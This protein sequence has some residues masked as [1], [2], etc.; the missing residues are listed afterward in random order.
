[1]RIS[2]HARLVQSIFL[3]SS[4]CFWLA[5]TASAQDAT[6]VWNALA[7]ASFDP[8]KSATAENVVIQHD[9]IRITLL[10]GTIQF[11]RVVNG[12]VFG[13]AFRGRGKVEIDPPNS[14]EAHQLYL[15]VGNPKLNLEFTDAVLSF[16]DDTLAQVTRQVRWLP[17]P[18]VDLASLYNGRQQEREDVG[19]ELLPRLF[20]SVLS[21]D[22][23]RTALFAADVKTAEKGWVHLRFDALQPEE[24][25][26]GRFANWGGGIGFDTWMKFPAGGV[27]AADAFR[28]PMAREDFLIPDYRIDATVTGG[29]EL[30]AATRL[31]L[32]YRHAG[33]RVF[34][35]FLTSNL[36]VESVKDSKGAALPFFQ[37]RE[38]K[39]RNQSYGD[40]VAV[41][42]PQPTQAGAADTLE[43]RYAG[44]RVI[45]KVG[46]GNFFC[47]SYG[48]YPTLANS[49]A[50][51]SNF[52]MTFRS[53]KKYTLVVTG[54]KVSE[55]PD[56]DNLLSTWKSE[57]PLAVVG[58][59]FGD[60]KL[61]VEKVGAIDVEVYANR[62]PDENM[63][64][65]KTIVDQPMTGMDQTGFGMP[66]MGTLSPAAMVKTMGTELA[67]TVRVFEKYFGPFPFK[68]LAVTNI[69]YAYGQ[70]WPTLLYLS[71]LSF[72]DS[73]QRN[74]LGIK[75]QLEL[76]DF[77]RAHESSHQWW[78][79][80]VGWKSYHDQW[81]SEGFA[82]FSGNLYIQ[83]RQDVGEY[84]NRIRQ[85][86]L[87]MTS[88]DLRSRQYQSLG[89]VWMGTR[90]SSSDAPRGYSAVI[91]YKGGLILHMLR[92]MMFDTRAKEPDQRFI[93]MMQDFTKT[94]FN[95]PASTE[96][97]KAV[98][99]K[100]ITPNLDLDGNRR[101]DW[102]FRQYVYG[103]GIP[104][105]NMYYQVS[106]NGDGKWK[107]SGRIGQ[108][109]VPEGWKDALALYQRVGGK[110]TR[111]GWITV[112]QKDTP[113]DFVLPA[114]P[115]KLLLNHSEDT[116]ADIKQ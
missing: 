31:A 20:K 49:F 43:F 26:V 65:I 94:Y 15:F 89:P 115:E 6:Q 96:D 28:D 25:L 68:R 108:S 18:P 23:K 107:I 64:L 1:M 17:S 48:W 105:Y 86:K 37:P 5:A 97:F 91:Y 13:A 73:T 10:S 92:M 3:V 57:I 33:E 109:G 44:K 40:Y 36:R 87:Y 77:F 84:V 99:E 9:R 74:A 62:D 100:H 32:S 45:R 71:A 90:L 4:F 38:Q 103:T 66:A 11:S 2:R 70:G 52:D 67:N 21:G 35:F 22:P 72:L 60:Y 95:K 102:F 93:A 114:K 98:A 50:T 34:L 79:H 47:Q 27:S 112:T 7:Q 61:Q 29:A 30:S 59:A 12:V 104:T 81:L 85:D 55:T 54:Q 82:Q 88:G 111:L 80:A 116:L 58:F 16:A 113:F 63:N 78:G 76:S 83:Y 101:L 56:G 19:V 41:V 51:R 39:D 106:D 8:A 14:L 46:A 42:L 53:P 75:D 110:V 24:I 69:P